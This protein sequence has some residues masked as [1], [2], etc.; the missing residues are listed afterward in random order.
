[1]R[2]QVLNDG[3]ANDAVPV[4]L[5]NLAPALQALNT[6]ADGISAQLP[7]KEEDMAEESAKRKEMQN[8]QV[9]YSMG[10]DDDGDAAP[11]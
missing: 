8:M 3:C 11:V 2:L 5:F 7:K 10:D 1:M 9:W 6:M 4:P